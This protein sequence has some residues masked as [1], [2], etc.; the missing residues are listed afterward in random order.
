MKHIAEVVLTE[1]DIQALAASAIESM[2]PSPC[3]YEV[4]YH[5]HMGELI[6][7]ATIAQIKIRYLPQERE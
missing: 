6:D 7:Y 1:H 5:D 2:V 4:T 3:T